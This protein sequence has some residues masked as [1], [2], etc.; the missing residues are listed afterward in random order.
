MHLPEGSVAAADV[1]RLA[2]ALG[3]AGAPELSGT[4]WKVGA[5]KDGSGP[6]LSVDKQAPGSWTFGRFG[7]RPAVTTA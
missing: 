3:V 5:R 2:E 4:A 1:A 6:L 7:P